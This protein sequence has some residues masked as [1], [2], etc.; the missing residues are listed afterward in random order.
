MSDLQKFFENKSTTMEELVDIT[1][2]EIDKSKP[3]NERIISFI[4]Q[5][6]N[7]YYFKVGDTPVRVSFDPNGKSFQATVE[8]MIRNR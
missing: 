2:V 7:P 6:G 3:V 8:K 4:D 5:I 1:M